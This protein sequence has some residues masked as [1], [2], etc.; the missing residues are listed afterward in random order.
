MRFEVAIRLSQSGCRPEAPG[1][2]V[3]YFDCFTNVR[4]ANFTKVAKGHK[5]RRRIA[6][7]LKI[8]ETDI[9]EKREYNKLPKAISSDQFNILETVCKS[10]AGGYCVLIFLE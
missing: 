1:F 7:A 5:G 4:R 6:N 3:L 2:C 8:G 10:A 9:R